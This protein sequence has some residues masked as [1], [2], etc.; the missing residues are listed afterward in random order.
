LF[1]RYEIKKR[2]RQNFTSSDKTTRVSK[3]KQAQAHT[4]QPALHVLDGALQHG[5]HRALD[6][7]QHNLL[8][9]SASLW[10]FVGHGKN[11]GTAIIEHLLD[12]FAH[13]QNIGHVD[14]GPGTANRWCGWNRDK[15][16]L[17][18]LD[19]AGR[20]VFGKASLNTPSARIEQLLVALEKLSSHESGEKVVYLILP[21]GMGENAPRWQ[22]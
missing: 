21:G 3:N 15:V 5:Q 17:H 7:L 18:S 9:L 8:D 1:V 2:S 10:R 6:K 13:E 4:H 20:H 22:M 19:N 14:P 12:P 11:D 16:G